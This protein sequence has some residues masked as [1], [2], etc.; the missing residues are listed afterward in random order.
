MALL[1]RK[2]R[3]GIDVLPNLTDLLTQD[4]Y[5]EFEK[6]KILAQICSYTILFKNE[7]KV[8]VQHFMTLIKQPS[9]I[10]SNLIKVSS[11]TKQTFSIQF[12]KLHFKLVIG[13]LFNIW[14]KEVSFR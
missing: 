9:M 8:G 4:K 7:L 11:G 10:N 14:F 2:H 6:Q 5:N 13:T 3:A 1:V 12:L